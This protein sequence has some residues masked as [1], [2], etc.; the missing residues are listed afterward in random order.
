M[1]PRV[2]RAGAGSCSAASVLAGEEL[3]GSA[4]PAVAWLAL[5][6]DGPWGAKA[7]T[8]SHLDPD[9]GRALEAAATAAGV[10]PSLVRRPGRHA[11]AHESTARQVLVAHTVPGRSWLLS[12]ALVDPAPLLD[13][14]W[15][16]LA[17]GD[18]DGVRRSLAGLEPTGEHHLLVCTNGT[19]DVCCATLGRPV[20]AAAARVHPGRVWEVTH[21]SGHRFAPTAVLL[22]HG[23]L[24]G[25]L[26]AEA[27]ADLLT[28]A[29]RGETVLAGSR[30]RSTWSA[31]AQVAELAVRGAAGVLGLDDLSVTAAG[32]AWEIAHRD[33]RRW[34]VSVGRRP[35]GVQRPESCGKG[36]V[37]L[38]R[39]TVEAVSPV[40]G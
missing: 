2:G 22:P 8:A 26:D 31:P 39:W 10:R 29:S 16:A 32:E 25:R 23:T 33:G 34:L 17:Q 30:G 38:H 27:A 9:L 18:Q 21:T 24:H 6:Q 11:D 15:A 13:L 36:P 7:F 20:A 4:P 19:R 12:G 14:D 28:A 35:A 3:A 37:E 5:E 1:S 40:D